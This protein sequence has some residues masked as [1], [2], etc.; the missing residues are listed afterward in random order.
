MSETKSELAAPNVSGMLP[1]SAV[2]MLVEHA[3]K[4]PASD[5]FF[6]VN[7]NHLAVQVRHFGMIRLLTILTS[8]LGR[9]CVSYI[10][11]MSGLDLAETRRPLDGRWIHELSTG[12]R[13][14]LRITAALEAVL[15]DPDQALHDR[16]VETLRAIV[17][18]WLP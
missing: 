15:G 10:K 2:A 14:D 13:V 6:T 1:E 4:L 17:P 16:A 18:G 12:G 11:A 3:A 9:R 8:D 7:E 5:L